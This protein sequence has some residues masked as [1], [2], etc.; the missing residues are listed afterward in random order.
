VSD[1]Q[2]L[3]GATTYYPDL[4]TGGQFRWVSSVDWSIDFDQLD[5]ISLK[6]G[7]A[8]EYQS[9]TSSGVPNNDISTFATLVI[10]F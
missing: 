9:K 1:R 8:H 4:S 3:S 10:K 5:G 7:L 2:S 6:I